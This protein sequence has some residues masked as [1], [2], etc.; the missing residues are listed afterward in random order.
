MPNR[1]SFVCF[2]CKVGYR[3][4]KYWH[5]SI[6]PQCGGTLTEIPYKMK[7]PKKTASRKRWGEF[8]KK[9]FEVERDRIL[10]MTPSGRKWMR[11][12]KLRKMW[13]G[14]TDENAI[15]MKGERCSRQYWGIE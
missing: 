6:C 8:R 4:E 2:D 12:Y 10:G 14:K 13:E 3:R 15:E 7:V 11:G 5:T 1:R 9:V